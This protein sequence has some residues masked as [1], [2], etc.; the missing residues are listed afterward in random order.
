MKKT[1]KLTI[2]TDCH[3]NLVARDEAGSV[4]ARRKRYCN[5]AAIHQIILDA[6]MLGEID[7]QESQVAQ[8]L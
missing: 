2:D 4:L 6:E 5:P 3:G 7:W 8:P 1:T